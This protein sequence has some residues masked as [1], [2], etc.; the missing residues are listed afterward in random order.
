MRQFILEG[1]A[2]PN[3]AAAIEAA[4]G[5]L[6]G[7]KSAKVDF[8]ATTLTL[9]FSGPPRELEKEVT[10]LVQEVDDEVVVKRA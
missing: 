4:A 7:V 9:E 1:L 10:D 5:K 6:P 8:D 2:C 3:C